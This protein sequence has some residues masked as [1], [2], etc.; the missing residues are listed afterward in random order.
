MSRSRRRRARDALLAL[1]VAAGLLLPGPS[2]AHSPDVL[3]D[4]VHRVPD[5]TTSWALYGTFGSGDE[6]FVVRLSYDEG[7]ALPVSILVPD[8]LGAASRRPAFAVVGPGLPEPDA[9]V[10]ARLPREV[11]PGAGVFF[12]PNPAAERER[13]FEPVTRRA[14]WTSRPT[15]LALEPGD[16]EVWIWSPDGTRGDF[17]FALGVEESF[18]VRDVVELLRNW[19]VY[20]G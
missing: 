12:E 18:G 16:H 1:S 14:F 17:V 9:E 13:F 11:P 8:E 19:D 2:L 15:A 4:Q 20:A 5:P 6:L 7:F 3:D 10:R